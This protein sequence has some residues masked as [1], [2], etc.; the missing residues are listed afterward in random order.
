MDPRFAAAE[1]AFKANRIDEGV[2]LLSQAITDAK[3]EV[4]VGWYRRISTMLFQAARYE[5]ARHWTE[6]GLKRYRKDFDLWNVL[7][8][9]QRRLFNYPAAIAALDQAQKLNPKSDA[10]IINKTNV[11]NDMGDGPRGLDGAL[12]LVRKSPG[13]AEYHRMAAIAYRAMHDW[14]KARARLETAVRLQP[15]LINAWVDRI[16]VASGLQLHDE[17]LDV[18]NRGLVANPD[19]VRLQ[20]TKAIVLR[21]AGHGAETVA[22]LKDIIEADDTVAWAH[23]QL[24]RTIADDDRPQANTHFRR[25]VE[26]D[27]RNRDFRISLVQ[28]LERSR[29]GDE[30][31]NL[32][33]AYQLLRGFEDLGPIPRDQLFVARGLY[34]RTGDYEGARKLGGFSE[35]GREWARANNH[36]AFLGHLGRV[37]T[38]E[39]RYELIE[40]HRIWGRNIQANADRNPIKNRPRRAPNGK[41]RLGLMSSDLRNHPVGYFALPLFDFMD[42]ERFEVFCY[43]FSRGV[44]DNTQKYFTSK[45]TAFRWRPTISDRD[46]AQM[47]VDDDCDML[48]E[49]GGSTHMNK[50]EVMAY[51]PGRLNASWL[52]YP[53]S[54]GLEAIDYIVCDPYM[55]PKD[56]ALLI[57]KPMIMPHT[58][59]A[60]GRGQFREKPEVDPTTPEE[61]NGFVT[62]GTFN[63]PNK[64]SPEVLATWARVLAETPNSQFLFVRPE[65]SSPTF[66]ENMRAHFAKA[67]VASERVRF[68]AVRGVHLPLYNEIDITLDTFPLTGGTTTCECMWM[69][70]PVVSLVGEALFE[71]LSYS[72][73]SNA[74]LGD[75]ATFNLDDFV[76]AAV[77]LA[78]DSAR[79]MVLRATLR[80]QLKASPLGQTQAFAKDFYDLVYNTVQAAR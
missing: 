2:Q 15:N 61:R 58:W 73:L 62:F 5:E 49:L 31:A 37:E 8:V 68:H 33:E 48:I 11:Y 16:S 63:Q 80:D 67:G 65:G 9:A 13:V 29:F 7:G 26:L 60:L 21:R 72:L 25:A 6:E 38:P 40:Q 69:G 3:G 45:A 51:R 41:I 30:G 57:E 50:L 78:K 55:T 71:R 23:H 47:I 70:V 32:E 43:S 34:H 36:A 44:E 28:S 20:E 79:R 74:G 56:P 64:Y 14:D 24:G 17:A 4:Q 59:L 22:Y 19:S 12:R 35:L 1:E 39:D 75:L 54:A 42:N 77:N 27:P 10:P 53:H 76:A 66:C 46:A 52:G 18:I